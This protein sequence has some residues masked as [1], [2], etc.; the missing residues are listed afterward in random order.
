MGFAVTSAATATDTSRL[1]SWHWYCALLAVL[2]VVRG[3]FLLCF[4]P[5]LEGPDEY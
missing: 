2:F 4:S 5:P 3:L 1:K